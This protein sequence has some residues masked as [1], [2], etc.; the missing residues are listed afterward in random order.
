MYVVYESITKL[1]ILLLTKVHTNAISNPTLI[2]WDKAQLQSFG[3]DGNKVNFTLV[4]GLEW[5]F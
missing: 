5:A 2:L 1:V 3:R 4:A